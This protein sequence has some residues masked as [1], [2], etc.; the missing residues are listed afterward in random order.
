MKFK[1]YKDKSKE[2]R[3]TLF[4]TNGRKIADS[5]EGYKRIHNCLKIA[6]KLALKLGAKVLIQTD[7]A[8]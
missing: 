4:V 6:N 1:L 5:A 8:K 2:W 7:E 3:W